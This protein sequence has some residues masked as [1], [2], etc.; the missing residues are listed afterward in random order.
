MDTVI[1]KDG[2]PIAYQRSGKGSVLVLIHGTTSDHST[3]WKFILA[4]LEEHFTVYAMDRRG[5]GESGDGPA[6]SLDREAEDVAV[7]IDSIGQPVNVLG[8][9]YGALCAIKAALLT[10]NIRRL[11]LYEGV[12]A[13]GIDLYK[14]GIIDEMQKLIDSGKTEDALM[15]MFREV[16]NMPE[17]EIHIL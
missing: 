13:R 1:S 9:S 14:P 6:Y 3:T 17:D 15:I 16:V 8:H 7:L 12:P 4:S 10:N 2:T 5:R 11:I